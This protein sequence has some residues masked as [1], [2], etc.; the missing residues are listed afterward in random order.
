MIE[1]NIVFNNAGENLALSQ[2]AG[3]AMEGLMDSPLHRA[4]ILSPEYTK[5]GIG[6]MD[7]GVYGLMVTQV[8]SN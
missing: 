5:I 6:I 3:L 4:N 1:E 2:N 8:F 7:G